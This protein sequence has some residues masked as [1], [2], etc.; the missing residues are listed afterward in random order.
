M[1]EKNKG[2]VMG[3]FRSKS[4]CKTNNK[5]NCIPK[6]KFGINKTNGKCRK[7]IRKY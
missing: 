2:N 7:A 5:K 6:C 3:G 1:A 4:S